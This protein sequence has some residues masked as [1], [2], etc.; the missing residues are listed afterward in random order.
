MLG[1][2][3]VPDDFDL[4]GKDEVTRLYRATTLTTCGYRFNRDRANKR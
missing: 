3:A 2:F 4:M 1:E